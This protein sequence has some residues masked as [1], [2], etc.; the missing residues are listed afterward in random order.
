[1]V[2]STPTS[3]DPRWLA[4]CSQLASYGPTITAFSGGIDSTLVAYA[5]QV[6][7]A[8]GA[9]AVT[10]ISASLAVAERNHATQLAT[11]VGLTHRE[12]STD[13][14]QRPGYRANLGDRCYH[15]K[16]ELF[17]L[18]VE[19]ARKEGFQAV[20]SGDNLDDLGDH[21]P[22]L[23]AAR[24][25][26]IVQPL[27]AAKL[28]KNDIRE[29]A[30]ILGLPNSEKP[31]APCLASRIPVGISVAPEILAKIDAS[32]AYLHQLG[33]EVVRVRHH[34]DVARIEVPAAQL[35]K[36][37][38]VRTQVVA[39]LKKIGY[40]HVSVDLAGF[41]SGSLNILQPSQAS[42]PIEEPLT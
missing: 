29:L 12:I 26:G 6:V 19:L 36:L 31:A 38:E 41:R 17:T 2:L 40:R 4:L 1:M 42:K 20:A 28:G 23:N 39:A 9:L 11:S 32:E 21:R 15:C 18:L 10:G 14:Q 27:I 24:E 22:G 7:H 8:T 3:N 16:T 33:F 34:D 5:S 35:G 37:L 25:L 13:E 30:R